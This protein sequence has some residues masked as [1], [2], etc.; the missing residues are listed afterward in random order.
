MLGKFELTG[1]PP[2]PRGVTKISIRFDIDADGIL[3][4]SAEDQTT[5]NKK[6]M[7]IIN[8]KGRLSTYEIERMLQEA[9]L[10]KAEDEQ[11]RWTVEAMNALENY[12]TA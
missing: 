9:E 5:G 11:H 10:F 8:D 3:D 2:A 1:I 7:T 4:V 12:I 6:N